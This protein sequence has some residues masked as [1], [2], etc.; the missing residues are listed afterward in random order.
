MIRCLAAI[1]ALLLSGPAFAQNSSE[2]YHG[3]SRADGMN[4]CGGHDCRALVPNEFR[5][6]GNGYEVF[7]NGKW[8]PVSPAA[9][10]P[11]VPSWDGRNHA[12]I[13][14]YSASDGSVSVRCLILDIR[15]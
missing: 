4:C 12:C 11:D 15:S 8:L 9:I 1:A 3:L 5:E 13:G 10:L 2:Y 14:D 6:N 7:Y